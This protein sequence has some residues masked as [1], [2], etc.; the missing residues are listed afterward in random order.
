ME[1]KPAVT[2]FSHQMIRFKWVEC[3]LTIL[4]SCRTINRV[5]IVLSQL[6]QS[7]E[8]TY[9]RIICNISEDNVTDRNLAEEERKLAKRVLQLM[10]VSYRP[11]TIDEVADA[12]TVDISRQII[13][14]ESM[15]G[16]PSDILEICSSLIEY[17]FNYLI[18]RELM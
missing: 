16:H 15:L 12:L 5:R 1:C 3:L 18:L 7:L 17:Q 11:L 9:E 14:T 4:R 2:F 10:A 8:N 6:P 13:D